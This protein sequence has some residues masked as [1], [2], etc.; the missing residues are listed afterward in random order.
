MDTRHRW[1]LGLAVV[2]GGVV[3][4]ACV[5]GLGRVAGWRVELA[6]GVGLVAALGIEAAAFIWRMGRPPCGSSPACTGAE[7]LVGQRCRA[8]TVLAP[9]GSVRVHGEIWHARL[10]DGES[11][12]PGAALRV[13]AV[14]GLRL[15]VAQERGRD[16]E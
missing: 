9:E 3:Y 4:T 6:I 15:Q 13:V 7:G 5:L 14:D 16:R 2:G 10:A 8:V 11:A 12:A 1:A